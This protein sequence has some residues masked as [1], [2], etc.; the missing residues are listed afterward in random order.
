MKEEENLNIGTKGLHTRVDINPN[1]SVI[2]LYRYGLNVA[3]TK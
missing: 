1:T 2:T 3:I